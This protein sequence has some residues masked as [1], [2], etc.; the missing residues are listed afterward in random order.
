MRSSARYRRSSTARVVGRFPCAVALGPYARAVRE[1][2]A[3][4][5]GELFAAFGVEVRAFLDF[6]LGLLAK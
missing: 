5:L 4:A 2:R 1:G 6:R 3:E